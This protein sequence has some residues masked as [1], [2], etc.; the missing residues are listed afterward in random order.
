MTICTHSACIQMMLYSHNVAMN[1]FACRRKCMLK[2]YVLAGKRMLCGAPIRNLH[3]RTHAV[4]HMGT[5][6]SD[7]S[8]LPF[9]KPT[10]CSF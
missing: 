5:V 1:R 7:S 4:R 6:A 10:A 3:K 9:Q 2:V 8:S